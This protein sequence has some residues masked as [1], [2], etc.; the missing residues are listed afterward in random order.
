MVDQATK[1]IGADMRVLS[2]TSLGSVAVSM[3]ALL[4]SACGGHGPNT[5][6]MPKDAVM[7]KL[8]GASKHFTQTLS[9]RTDVRA[10]SWRGDRLMVNLTSSGGLTKMCTATVE[11]I[12]EEWT[13]VTPACGD[14]NAS[15]VGD[16]ME[17]QINRMKVDEFVI[18]VLYDRPMN[19]E[20]IANRTSAVVVGSIGDIQRETHKSMR[21]AAAC[22]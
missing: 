17:A 12:D 11:A 19:E 14:E 4:L 21:E 9:G 16:A 20:A 18:A 6:L 1:G 22:I 8:T 3:G 5:Y 15:D 2:K 13:R 10:V 7:E